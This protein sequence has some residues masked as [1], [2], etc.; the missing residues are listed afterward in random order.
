MNQKVK[1]RGVATS[2]TYFA[3]RTKVARRESVLRSLVLAT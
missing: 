2:F 3:L 1:E